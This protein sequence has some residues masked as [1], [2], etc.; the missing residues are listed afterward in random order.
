MGALAPATAV[1][2]TVRV[3]DA[4]RLTGIGRSKL[5]MLI[6]EG[7]IEVRKVGNMTLIP[8]RSLEAFLRVDAH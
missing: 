1:P 7:H 8:M 2:L 6:S 5:Y 3:R 4:C